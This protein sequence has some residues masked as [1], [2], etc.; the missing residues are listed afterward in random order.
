MFSTFYIHLIPVCPPEGKSIRG[1]SPSKTRNTLSIIKNGH[2]GRCETP[3]VYFFSC[4]CAVK[5]V[6]LQYN[7]QLTMATFYHGSSVLFSRFDLAHVL[8]GDGKVKFGYGVYLTSSF[9]SAAH[10]SGANKSATT[11]Y[12]YTVEVA[13]LSED[14]H[15]DFKQAVHPSIIAR[16]EQKLGIAIP[17]KATL[18]GKDFRKFLAKHLGG[19]SDVQSEKAA[20]E[21]LTSIGVDFITWPYSWKNPSLGLNI[22]VLDDKK[23]KIIAV[24]QVELDNKQQLVEGTEKEVKL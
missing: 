23:V 2:L 17:Q 12:V 9:K 15:I 8:E 19:G 3:K 13:D 6:T 18:D 22:A 7:I 11:H 10:Y 1:F 5:S 14:N 20:S 21:F 24:H 4:V 16:A